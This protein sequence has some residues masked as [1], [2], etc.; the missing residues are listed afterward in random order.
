M[1]N[2]D[3]N[4]S[5]QPRTWLEWKQAGKEAYE[6]GAFATALECYQ[7]AL[8]PQYECAVTADR[9]VLLSNVVACRLQLGQAEEALSDAKACVRLNEAWPKAHVRLA[10]V[11][12]ALHRSNEACNSLQ[13]ALRLD[14]SNRLARDM[15]VRELR[16]DQPQRP[17]PQN[18]AYRAPEETTSPHSHHPSS[19][20]TTSSSNP[21][22]NTP[23]ATVNVDDAWTWQDQARWIKSQI[24]AWYQGQSDTVR[25]GL[26]IGLA[27][28]LWAIWNGGSLTSTRPQTTHGNY[29]EG[30]AYDAYYRQRASSS[31]DNYN[32]YQSRDSYY[33]TSRRQ[34]SYDPYG[35]VY[36]QTTW[37]GPSL[38][39]IAIV[40]GAA[41]FMHLQG[42]NPLNALFLLNGLG[43]RRRFGG[44][45]FGG[46][47]YGGGGMYAGRRRQ[48]GF[49]W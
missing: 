40:A 42:I 23:A 25:Y 28:I 22:P 35:T 32:P 19:S 44:G 14:P 11:Y 20:S 12:Q 45:M 34:S 7:T 41:Y 33:D 9:Q 1:L 5:P 16:R 29:G 26:W 8:Q 43:R 6:R 30:N 18:P 49:Y 46:G 15:L 48:R 4:N 17:P 21:R 27:V 13:T 3:S 39:S 2:R 47:M 24:L 37:S 38:P 10:A 31:Y 36:S